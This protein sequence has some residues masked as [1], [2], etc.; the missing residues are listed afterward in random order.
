[1]VNASICLKALTGARHNHGFYCFSLQPAQN[2]YAG[3]EL[4]SGT[5]QRIYR[6]SLIWPAHQTHLIKLYRSVYL[7]PRSSSHRTLTIGFPT[8]YTL[9][10]YYKRH[11]SRTPLLSCLGLIQTGFLST[12]Q[13]L[14]RSF[15]GGSALIAGLSF[16]FL[17]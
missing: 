13:L 6:F 8:Y 17:S 2:H 11:R 15:H 9:L 3:E 14:L 10:P 5:G 16:C 4:L 7:F 1:M 12:F